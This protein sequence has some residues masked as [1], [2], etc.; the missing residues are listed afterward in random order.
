MAFNSIVLPRIPLSPANF[1]LPQR[2]TQD[3]RRRSAGPVIIRR[4]YAA[5]RR[6]YAEERKEFV[7]DHFGFQP[8]WF[9]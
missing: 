6:L 8:F 3:R 1:S 4:E 5:E 9:T 2:I 7:R